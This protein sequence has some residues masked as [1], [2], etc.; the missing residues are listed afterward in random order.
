MRT[1]IV[2]MIGV[3]AIIWKV[4]KMSAEL[5]RVTAEVTETGTAIDSA[6]V[7][8][9][10]LAA[11]IRDLADDPAALNALADEL[12]SKSNALAS[13]VAANTPATPGEGEGEDTTDGTAA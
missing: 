7:L 11:Q 3:A 9:E 8:I 13:A 6:I 10:G 2:I 1:D 4:W 5:D 12:D